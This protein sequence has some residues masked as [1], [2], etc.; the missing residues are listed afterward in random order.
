MF[1]KTKNSSGL[2]NQWK[3]LNLIP[4]TAERRYWTDDAEEQRP[5]LN[6]DT[7]LWGLACCSAI[8]LTTYMC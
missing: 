5:E 2:Y 8:V 4:E 7:N 6:R 1:W 3:T